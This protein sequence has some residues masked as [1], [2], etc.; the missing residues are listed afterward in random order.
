M[1]RTVSKYARIIIGDSA[2]TLRH[3]PVDTINGIGL[4]YDEV[5]YQPFIDQ[6][7]GV[8]VNLPGFSCTIGGP[9]DNT[10]A[11]ATPALSGSHTVLEPLN[12]LNTPRSFDFQF[13]MGAAWS[14]GAP[15]FGM[16][17]TATSGIIVTDYQVIPS[18][19][20]EVKYSAKLSLLAGS[21]LP[22]WGTTAETGS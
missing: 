5:S 21:A 12:G 4:T 20:G 9:F 8:L 15:Q 10:A 17:K 7:K 11:A 3:I 16:T 2:D 22:A 14:S 18:S 13:G 1:A 19:N 6:I